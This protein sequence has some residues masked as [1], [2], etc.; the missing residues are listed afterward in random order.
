[1]ASSQEG[2]LRV[3]AKHMCLREAYPVCPKLG[4]STQMYLI[5]LPIWLRECK[6][7]F[8]LLRELK[9]SIVMK[10]SKKIL[11]MKSCLF[12]SPSQTHLPSSFLIL[13]QN[14]EYY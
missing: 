9:G 4:D 12:S 1:M 5:H 7:I 14:S 11:I 2:S 10:K 8:V 3:L 13:T 6:N